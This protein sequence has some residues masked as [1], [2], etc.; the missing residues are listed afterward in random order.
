MTRIKRPSAAQIDRFV[1][2]LGKQGVRH[3]RFELPDMHGTSR[4]KVVPIDAVAGYAKRGL[5]FYGGTL[6]LDTA[7]SVVP[8]ALYHEQVKYRDQQLIPELSTVRPVPWLEDTVKVICDTEWAPGEPLRA[9][10]RYVLR[11]L[12]ERA[13][14]LG[15]EAMMGHEFEFYVLDGETMKPPFDGLQIFNVV[16]N[17]YMPVIDDLLEFLPA[18]GIDIITHNCEYAPSQFEINYRAG[19]GLAAADTAFTFKNAVKE[20]CHRGG[21]HATFMTKPFPDS[22]GCGCHFHISLWDRKTGR[23]VF[24][25]KKTADGLSDTCRWFIQGV[26]DHAPAMM[27]LANPT[28]NCYRRLKPHTFAPSNISWG[29]EDRTA[30]VRVKATGDEQTHIEVR[31][32]SALSNPYLAAAG[33]LAGGL[34]GLDKKKKLQRTSKGVSEAD[35]GFAPLPATLDAALDALARDRVYVKAL[36]EEFVEVFSAVKR[37]ELGRFHEHISDWETSEYL[38]VY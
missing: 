20:I 11:Q 38:D 16:R 19:K 13:A 34:L 15:F 37:F 24:L 5:N 35:A 1:R 10:P 32:P 28:P 18:A 2:D 6:A 21:M 12:L 23:N 7:S 17:Q 3:V 29:I 9:A 27:A 25:D 26:L 22:A 4:A 30:L 33:A 31:V 8:G 14:A 36:G